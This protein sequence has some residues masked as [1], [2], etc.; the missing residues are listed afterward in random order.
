MHRW[1]V[2]ECTF[3]C[4]GM[5]RELWQPKHAINPVVGVRTASMVLGPE[6]R[7]ECSGRPHR[8]PVSSPARHICRSDPIL[9]ADISILTSIVAVKQEYTKVTGA[10]CC[11]Y[12]LSDGR[13]SNSHHF[14]RG[15]GRHGSSP[16]LWRSAKGKLDVDRCGSGGGVGADGWV[17]S[18][19][20]RCRRAHAPPCPSAT[21]SSRLTSVPCRAALPKHTEE[22]EIREGLTVDKEGRHREATGV[23]R[24]RK[25]EERKN[26][27]IGKKRK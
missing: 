15:E 7:L 21:S 23:K 12:A 10:L 27:G 3:A 26:K 18:P 17:T 20:H 11:L 25:E 14:T 22:E 1:A 19:E 5:T 2:H 6:R 9:A 4:V 13:E 24:R 16:N 8:T